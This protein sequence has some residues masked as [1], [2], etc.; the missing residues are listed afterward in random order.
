MT[1]RGNPPDVQVDVRRDV[2]PLA[3]H[4]CTLS[5]ED[6]RGVFA[7]RALPEKCERGVLAAVGSA[8]RDGKAAYQSFCDRRGGLQGKAALARA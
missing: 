6:K 2:V 4:K 5:E 3:N 1:H 7:L 8:A